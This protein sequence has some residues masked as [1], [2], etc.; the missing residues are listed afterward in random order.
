MNTFSEWLSD[1]HGKK[2]EIMVP[3]R[4]PRVKLV[5][6]ANRNAQEDFK[7]MFEDKQRK[8]RLIQS[9]KDAL[10][11]G[12]LPENIECYDISNTQG[13]LAVASM[14]RFENGETK[15]DKY[16]RFKIK[17]VIGANDYAMMYEFL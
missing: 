9:I 10:A 5:E 16:K 17:T 8:L 7:R 15:K 1:K 6:V 12:R 14:V 4:G 2:I 13:S 3:K 11:L